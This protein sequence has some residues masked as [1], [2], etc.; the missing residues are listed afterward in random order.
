MKRLCKVKIR[1]LYKADSNLLFIKIYRQI[2]LGTVML[3]GISSIASADSFCPAP[4][5]LIANDATE[6][7]ASAEEEGGLAVVADNATLG[8]DGVTLLKGNVAMRRAE[9]ILRANQ[10]EYDQ[11]QQQVRASDDVTFSSGGLIL[12][13]SKA[14]VDLAANN[15]SFE[16]ARFQVAGENARGSASKIDVAGDGTPD[17][18]GVT[19]TTCPP[20]NESWILKADRIRLDQASGQGKANNVSLRFKGVPIFYFPYMQFP[21]TDQR[22]SGLLA[23]SFGSSDSSGVQFGIP[24]YWN[25]APQMDATFTPNYLSRRGWRLDSEYR[26]ITGTPL[27]QRRAQ[28]WWQADTVANLDWLPD[29]STTGTSRHLLNWQ[30]NIQGQKQRRHWRW[31]NQLIDVKDRTWFDDFGSGLAEVSQPFFVSRSTG[32]WYQGDLHNHVSIN[33]VAEDHEPLAN[34]DTTLVS[35][36]PE[37][38]LAMQRRLGNS[39]FSVGLA[40]QIGRFN[41]QGESTRA[42]RSHY[43]PWLGFDLRGAGWRFNSRANY[44]NTHWRTKADGQADIT[45][46]RSLPVYTSALSFHLEKNY[47][48]GHHVIE[49]T[50]AFRAAPFRDQA[51]IPVLDTHTETLYWHNLDDDQFSGLDRVRDGKQLSATLASRWYNFAGEQRFGFRVGQLWYLNESTVTLPNEEAVGDRSN[52]LY[53]LIAAIGKRWSISTSGEW[54]TEASNVAH[55]QLR[56]DLKDSEY[57]DFFVS[58]RQRRNLFRQ[59]SFGGK[60]QISSQWYADARGLYSLDDEE[61]LEAKL[62][63][64]YQTCCWAIDFGGQRILRDASGEPDV[65]F[66]IQLELSGLAQIGNQ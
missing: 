18:R 58:L 16:N 50:L 43:Q 40:S 62:K 28:E 46:R 65:G 12:E 54:D 9:G 37:L 64:R 22:Q 2:I 24:Y 32:A 27:S 41:F 33:I 8:N 59:V 55:S 49:P 10:L 7:L 53:E 35:R 42:N 44:L 31:E 21:F 3:L 29:D 26:A 61:L 66:F 30:A 4:A 14:D 56:V 48:R 15:A 5:V 39:P 19:Y 52:T 25:I 11:A 6:E 13:S 51:D 36:Q 57:G 1:V 45:Q 63:L 47:Q 34:S 17:M 23:P 38:A 60:R 20:G